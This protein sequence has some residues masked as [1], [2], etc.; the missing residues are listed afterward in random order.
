MCVHTQVTPTYFFRAFTHKRAFPP[1]IFLYILVVY[2]KQGIVFL[3][4]GK[5]TYF[6]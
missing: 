3:G 1:T 6:S 2:G 5:T 4:S